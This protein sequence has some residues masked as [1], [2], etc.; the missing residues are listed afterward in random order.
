MEKHNDSLVSIVLCFFNEERFLAEAVNSILLQDYPHWELILVDDGSSD[1]SVTIAKK[2]AADYPGKI[3]YTNHQRH[4]NKGLSASRNAGI[5][6]S[7]GVFIAFIDADDVWLPQKLSF[8]LNIFKHHPEVSVLVEASLYWN[9]WTISDRPDVI[10]P[11]GV[12]EGVYSPPYLME[13]LYPLGT[14]SAPC[15]SGIMIRSDVTERCLFEESFRDIYQMY[16][17][18]GFLSKVYLKEKIYV[19][20][21]CNNKYR[22]RPASLVSSVQQNGQYHLVRS[23]YLQWLAVY[24]KYQSVP[25]H[26]LVLLNKARAPYLKPFWYKVTTLYPKIVKGYT[27]KCLVKVGVLNYNKA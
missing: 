17:D 6:K 18:Q 22:Q 9:S 25:R 7:R 11:V 15:P 1:G 5:K 23:Y 12:K 16:E 2:Y 10:V 4:A 21:A 14:G 24:L 19:S 13:A 8:Q 26:I 3:L 20:A 27:A